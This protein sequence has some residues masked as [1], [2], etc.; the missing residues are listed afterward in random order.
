MKK[1]L[2]SLETINALI[3]VEEQRVLYKYASKVRKNGVIV[4]I[5][6]AA[7]GSA[8]M[9]AFGSKPS[10]K[11]HTIDPNRNPNF[12]TKRKE[13]NFDKKIKF[14][15]KI[16]EEVAKDFKDKIDLLFVD[17]IHNYLG[18]T[19][20]FNWF[21]GFMKKDGIV[22]FHDYYAYSNTIGSAVDDI[23]KSGQVEKVKI[24][25]SKFR[26][27]IRTGLYIARMK[28]GGNK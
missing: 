26:G 16:S 14:I 4:D 3:S 25:D 5:G 17:G 9:L 28:G 8:F 7:G 22:M 12:F 20:D 19:N 18:V 24:I 23:V 21:K 1:A 27:E 2:K 11:I 10:V 13:F 6:T 15:N